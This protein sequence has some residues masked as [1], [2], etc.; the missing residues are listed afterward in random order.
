MADLSKEL[1]QAIDFTIQGKE[2]TV[3]YT[4]PWLPPKCTICG[5]WGH[6]DTF[7]NVMKK[8]NKEGKTTAEESIKS[9]KL[10]SGRKN[11]A[12]NLDVN[13]EGEKLEE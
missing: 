9:P 10:L 5:K 13:G 1:P 2:T 6:Y 12:E 8:D 4:Y 3:K 7:C 11:D